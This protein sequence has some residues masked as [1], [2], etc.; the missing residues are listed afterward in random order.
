VRARKFEIER[1]R[2]ASAI[3]G[4]AQDLVRAFCAK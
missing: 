3:D 2:A 1:L 4:A